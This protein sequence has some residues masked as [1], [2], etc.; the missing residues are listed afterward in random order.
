MIFDPSIPPPYSK[1]QTQPVPD[2]GFRQ[3]TTW[4]ESFHRQGISQKKE[5]GGE[6]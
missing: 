2:Y 1:T 5:F 6:G 3:Q 4:R